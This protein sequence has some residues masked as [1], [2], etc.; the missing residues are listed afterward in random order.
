MVKTLRILSFVFMG[1]GLAALI[2]DLLPGKKLA[3][4][5]I[6][7]PP[8][9]SIICSTQYHR[10]THPEKLRKLPWKSSV[11]IAVAAYVLVFAAIIA[12]LVLS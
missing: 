4:P 3:Y 7:I 8:I 9:L 2:Y 5:Y 11:T 12:V 6:G 1:I 10:M